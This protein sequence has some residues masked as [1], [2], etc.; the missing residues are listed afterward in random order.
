MKLTDIIVE[1]L[2]AYYKNLHN[3]R[4]YRFITTA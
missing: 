2:Y 4:L 3:S 1:M